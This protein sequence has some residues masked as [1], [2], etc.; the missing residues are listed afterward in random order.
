MILKKRMKQKRR[1]QQIRKISNKEFSSQA[2]AMQKINLLPPYGSCFDLMKRRCA[3]R[4][5]FSG[6]SKEANTE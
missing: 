6:A 3:L 1:I 4:E 2:K 5:V